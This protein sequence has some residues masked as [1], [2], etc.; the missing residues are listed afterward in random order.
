MLY[1]DILGIIYDY[2]EQL[3]IHCNKQ[4]ALE[5]IKQIDRYEIAVCRNCRTV[6]VRDFFHIDNDD[7]NHFFYLIKPIFMI[8]KINQD[9]QIENKKLLKP[10][11]FNFYCLVCNKY[12]F[13]YT[14][15]HH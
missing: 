10:Y 9:N 6:K 12:E 4:K 13:F 1:K 11:V 15:L 5:D 3:E 14:H 7:C 8:N 2:K